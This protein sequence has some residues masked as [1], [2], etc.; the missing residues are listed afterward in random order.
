MVGGGG[1]AG[2]RPLLGA[3]GGRARPPRPRRPRTWR[4]GEREKS[5][6]GACPGHT[7]YPLWDTWERYPGRWPATSDRVASV[8]RPVLRVSVDAALNQVVFPLWRLTARRTSL[9]LSLSLC[10]Q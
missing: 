9:S 1:E 6:E 4:C 5:G 3:P 8:S 7:R 10:S 2:S